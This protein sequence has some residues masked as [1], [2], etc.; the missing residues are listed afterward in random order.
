MDINDFVSGTYSTGDIEVIFQ[1]TPS[2]NDYGVPG[3]PTWIEVED[4]EITKLFIMGIEV[5]P[6][7]LPQ[8]LQD[9]I[10]ELSSEVEWE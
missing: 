1:G 7:E 2:K 3:S 4:P 10:Q 8:D 5:C 6:D 9:A